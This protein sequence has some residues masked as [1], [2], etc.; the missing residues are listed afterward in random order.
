MTSAQ[1]D[2]HASHLTML[3]TFCESAYHFLVQ[4]A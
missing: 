4:K 1:K 2:F 3:F